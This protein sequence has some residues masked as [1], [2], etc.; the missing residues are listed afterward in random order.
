MFEEEGIVGKNAL[1]GIAEL[2]EDGHFFP[3]SPPL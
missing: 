1:M 2:D 3:Q